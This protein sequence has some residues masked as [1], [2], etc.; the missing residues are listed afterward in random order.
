MNE[1]DYLKN[2]IRDIQD[3]PKEGVV[4]KDITPIL[5]DPDAMNKALDLFLKQL[6]DVKI[7]KVVGMESRGFF[8][9]TL[10]AQRL[11]A[12]FVPVRKPGKLP[13]TTLAQT[14]DLEY[15]QDKLEIHSDSIKK[16]ENVLI[17][18]D[19]LATGGTAKAAV[20]L[21][22]ALGGNIIQ[23]NF[24]IELTFLNG[25]KKLENHD[26]FSILKY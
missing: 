14:Y 1:I 11:N 5:S 15:G 19:V 12:G 26:V 8:F 16:G 18:D 25:I 20:K 13:F 9:G 2:K 4:F 22:E 17:H 7:D 21:V 6:K 3:F 10:L 24:L 23:L